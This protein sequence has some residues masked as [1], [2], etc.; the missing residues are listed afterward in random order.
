MERLISK[1]LS[2]E[3]PCIYD[4]EEHKN[5]PHHRPLRKRKENHSQSPLLLLLVFD[6][7]IARSTKSYSLITEL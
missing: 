1:F 7:S 3:K 2:N 4:D 6:H 5:Y